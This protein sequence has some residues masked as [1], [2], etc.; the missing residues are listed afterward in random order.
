MS[1][2]A[3]AHARATAATPAPMVTSWM[4]ESADPN[5]RLRG[6]ESDGNC[7]ELTESMTSARNSRTPPRSPTVIS[8]RW[9]SE[10]S[11]W[12]AR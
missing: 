5:L 4:C 12:I 9:L 3:A 7:P 6:E 10:V 11:F 8:N 1:R 2:Y